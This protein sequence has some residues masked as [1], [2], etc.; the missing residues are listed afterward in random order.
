LI[1]RTEVTFGDWLAYLDALPPAERARRTP[2][3]EGKL[4]GSQASLRLSRSAGGEWSITMQPA[5]GVY[6]ARAG[7]PIR[8]AKRARRAQQSW[9]RFPVTGISAEDGE[10]YAAWLAESGRLRGARL[11]TER[12]WERAAR[13][14]DDR[15]FPTGYRLDPDDADY[16]ETYGKD[17]QSMGPDEVG[18][19]PASRSPF[20]VDDLSGNAWEWTRSSHAP[21]QYVGRGGAYYYSAK[22]NQAVNRQVS[23]PTV[24]DATL[25]LRICA[26]AP[27][28]AL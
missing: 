21:G 23:V 18:S 10:A 25:G 26:S 8:Y 17:P 5:Q 19:H 3:V 15:E 13:G 6:S 12:E 7:E 2:L 16:D 14:A 27:A 9:L 20:G 11:C 22:T 24:H 4:G 28:S 1:G